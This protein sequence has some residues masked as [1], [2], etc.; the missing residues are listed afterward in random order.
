VSYGADLAA[1]HDAGFGAL[2]EAAADR[3]E[4]ELRERGFRTGL[5]V[6]LGCGSGILAERLTAAGYD[7]LGVDSSP[8]MLEIARRRAPAAEFVEDSA[9][10]LEP[11]PCVAV[12]AVGEVLGYTG[13]DLDPVFARIATALAP[14]G[15]FGFDLAGPDRDPEPRRGWHEGPGWLVAMEAAQ[16]QPG[17][18]LRRRIVTFRNA[19]EGWRRHEEVHTLRLHDPAEVADALAAAGLDARVEDRY[20]PACEPVPGLHVFVTSKP[21]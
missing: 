11:P 17:R 1:I 18:A 13:A 7:V 8:A 20:S 19:G 2:A 4:A 12:T 16:V 14:G 15:V 21:R 5:V 9:A 10:D 6:D 3:L